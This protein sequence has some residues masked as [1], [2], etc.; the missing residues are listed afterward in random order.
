MQYKNP[1][2]AKDLRYQYEYTSRK[3]YTSENSKI[4]DVFDGNR[5]KTLV[6]SGL[7]LDYRDVALIASMDGYQV[8]KQK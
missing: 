7:F 1:S 2:R 4:G 3:E 5:Y 6:A 8:F